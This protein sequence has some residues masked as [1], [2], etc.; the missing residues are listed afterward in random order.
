LTI[1]IEI[2]FDEFEICNPLCGKILCHK[3]KGFYF[4]VYNLFFYFNFKLNNIYLLT[5]YF[6]EDIKTCG[7]N[8]VLEE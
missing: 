1:Q 8:S 5:L 7:I 3:I 2:F 6:S 4:S